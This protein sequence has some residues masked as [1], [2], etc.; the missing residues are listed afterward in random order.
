MSIPPSVVIGA[1]QVIWP[2]VAEAAEEAAAKTKPGWDDRAVKIIDVLLGR[3]NPA[4]LDPKDL[5]GYFIELLK[6]ISPDL[7]EDKEKLIALI[8]DI[9][10][11]EK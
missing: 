11:E 8:K 6:I 10:I 2:F 4:K 9:D 5:I 7:L 1:L 3:I